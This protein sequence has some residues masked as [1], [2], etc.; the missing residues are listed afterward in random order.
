M[1]SPLSSNA[2]APTPGGS[3]NASST[4][5]SSSDSGKD[6]GQMLQGGSASPGNSSTTATGSTGSGPSKPANAT[7]TSDGNPGKTTTRPGDGETA[8]TDPA[9]S[10][11]A[12]PA[13]SAAADDKD[14]PA[15]ADDAPWPPLGLAGLVL[16]VPT[17]VDP[18]PV[19]PPTASDADGG[20]LPSAATALPAA[21][22]SANA[23]QGAAAP[24]ANA[25]ASAAGD[26]EASGLPLPE[27]VL[28]GK[29][30]DRADDGD[31]LQIGDRAPPAP[32]QPPLP[33]ALQDLK[34]A[35]ASNAVFN[36]E[37]TP[38]PV[39][40]DD[41]FDQAIGARIG[42]LADQKIGHA[43]IRL[44][45]EDLGP[46]DVRLQMNGDKVHA[47]FSSP[48]V[49]VRQALESSLPR[50]RELLGEQGFQ[51]AHADVGQ[52][53]SGDGNPG[54]QAAGGRGGDG[55][56]SLGDSTV[57]ASQLIRQRGLLD[58]YA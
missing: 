31:S 22:V 20:A 37:P 56:P 53:H 39:L 10:T 9:T 40:G 26:G 34:A 50:L 30:L 32:L 15:S 45:P 4:R 28:G 3:G 54:S 46:V 29:A 51:L 44:N 11:P 57:S 19:P 55:E 41:G 14:T 1:P 58:A 35:L 16:A 42:W 47:S 21:A 8:A 48:H 7:S 13:T 17:G 52:Q 24:A 27:L 6:F 25:S 23:A 43:H 33:A 5:T 36:G 49:D 2:S 38:K 12:V 18:A